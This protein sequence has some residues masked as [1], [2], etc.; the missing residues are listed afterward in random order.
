M[1]SD[2][3]TFRRGARP[4]LA[5]L[6]LLH[7]L[8]VEQPIMSSVSNHFCIKIH[9]T[10]PLTPHPKHPISS[11]ATSSAPFPSR[12]QSGRGDGGTDSTMICCCCCPS[13]STRTE[14]T[15]RRWKRNQPL[16]IASG[17]QVKLKGHP[18][19]FIDSFSLK[20]KDKRTDQK[21][22]CYFMLT[23]TLKSSIIE[24]VVEV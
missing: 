19:T 13:H 4:G 9:T 2:L 10:T 3:V 12:G 23:T 20:S 1:G 8:V 5:R 22:K 21:K 15:D 16:L 7:W 17:F 18:S 14:A 24:V 11:Q 6:C